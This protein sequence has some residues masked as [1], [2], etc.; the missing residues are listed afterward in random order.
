MAVS[1]WAQETLTRPHP[2]LTLQCKCF[3]LMDMRICTP[4][5]KLGVQLPASVPRAEGAHS[6]VG[7]LPRERAKRFCGPGLVWFLKLEI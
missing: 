5:L 7:Q 4:T 6:R 2:V 1:G 3:T